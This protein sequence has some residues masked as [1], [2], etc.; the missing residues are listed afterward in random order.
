MRI[1]IT[2]THGTGKTTLAMELSKLIKID[3][4]EIPIVH[5]V[6]RFVIK[7]SGYETTREYIEKTDRKQKEK[8]Q[9]NI[10]SEQVAVER[11]CEHFVADRSVFDPVA[12]AAAYG[13]DSKAVNRLL[14][15]AIGHALN[16]YDLVVYLPPYWMPENDGFRDTDIELWGKVNA[17][18][19]RYINAFEMLGGRVLRTKMTNLELRIHEVMDTVRNLEARH[20]AL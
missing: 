6:A 8:I 1:A 7:G 5:E 16:T 9:W 4:F 12:Y 3:G 15:H 10:F 11:E 17:N 20:E 13:V 14:G 19:V 2:G 18:I